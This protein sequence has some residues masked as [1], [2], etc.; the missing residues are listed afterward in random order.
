MTEKSKPK[1]KKK[2]IFTPKMENFCQVYVRTGNQAEAYRQAYDVRPN[3]KPEC[4]WVNGSRLMAKESIQRRVQEIFERASKKTDIT[5]ARLTEELE[6]ARQLAMQTEQASAMT[7]AT[8]GKAKINGLDVKKVD[9]EVSGKG[10]G[11]IQFIFNPVDSD[12]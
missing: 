6:E 1:K 11:P 2:A 7:S 12:D 9:V 5:V 4:I 8:M 10:G 3:T